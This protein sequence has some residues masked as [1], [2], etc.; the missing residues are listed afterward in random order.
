MLSKFINDQMSDPLIWQSKAQQL[1]LVYSDARKEVTA[2]CEMEES[3]R[4]TYA[5][6][7]ALFGNLT[8]TDF[9]K[10]PCI[11]VIKSSKILIDWPLDATIIAGLKY[12]TYLHD[13]M[14]YLAF[15][16]IDR[17]FYSE[18]TRVILVIEKTTKV[19]MAMKEYLG[20]LF[21]GEPC[22]A[23]DGEK[24][25][26]PTLKKGKSVVELCAPSHHEHFSPYSRMIIPFGFW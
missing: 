4:G 14:H 21:K 23:W 22:G 10:I 25:N 6:A 20:R 15:S 24:E 1:G 2:F 12:E 17:S 5:F 3:R 19:S 8:P 26:S 9:R 16:V 13:Y 11:G 18:K 7:V